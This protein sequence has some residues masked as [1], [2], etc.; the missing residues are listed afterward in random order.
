M[1][2]IHI[3]MFL[4]IIYCPFKVNEYLRNQTLVSN[5][6]KRRELIQI[7]DN[8]KV[9][10]NATQIIQPTASTRNKKKRISKVDNS[11][12]WVGDGNNDVDGDDDDDDDD[13]DDN[14]N[15]E[16]TF[17]CL[18]WLECFDY[19]NKFPHIQLYAYRG[20]Y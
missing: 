10:S 6:K 11:N 9:L 5:K 20:Y 4:L 19:N 7:S 12:H 16:V 15:N 1:I 14:N 3:Q 18:Y 13:A 8:R 17:Y 2:A